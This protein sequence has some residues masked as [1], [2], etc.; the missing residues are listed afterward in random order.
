[1]VI[2]SSKKLFLAFLLL[3]LFSVASSAASFSVPASVYDEYEA[4]KIERLPPWETLKWIVHDYVAAEESAAELASRP[5]SQGRFRVF[6][7]DA[8]ETDWE[9]A[10]PYGGNQNV[11]EAAWPA[12]MRKGMLLNVPADAKEKFKTPMFWY[13]AEGSGRVPSYIDADGNY[14][15]GTHDP[16]SDEPGNIGYIT[17]NLENEMWFKEL[18]ENPLFQGENRRMQ[19]HL[20]TGI[21][22]YTGNTSNHALARTFNMIVAVFSKPSVFTP[23]EVRKLGKPVVLLHAQIHG[24]ENTPGE[25][26]LQIAKELSEGKHDNILDKIT[27][28]MVPRVNP[29]GAWLNTRGTQSL[30]PVGH[31][32]QSAGAFDMNRDNVGFEA[33]EIKLIRYLANEYNPIAGYDGHEQGGN[34]DSGEYALNASGGMTSNGYRR[35]YDAGISISTA[36][37]FNVHRD[38]RGLAKFIYEPIM[39][40]ELNKAK[41]GANWYRS[42]T[43]SG[44]PNGALSADVVSSDG[45]SGPI[46]GEI[47]WPGS[48]TDAI[49]TTSDAVIMNAISLGNQ[50]INFCSE[51]SRMTSN[52]IARLGAMRIVYGQYISAMTILKVSAEYLDTDVMPTISMARDLEIA[53]ALPLTF[54]G[55]PPTEHVAAEW[56]VLEYKDWRKEDVPEVVEAIAPGTRPIREVRAFYAELDPNAAVTR[57]VAYIIDKEHYLAAVRLYYTGIGAKIERLAQDTTIPVEAYTVLTTGATNLSPQN[58]GNTPQVPTG[59]RS[60]S[61]ADKTMTFPKDSFVVRMDSLGGIMSALLLEPMATNNFGNMWLSRSRGTSGNTANIPAWYRDNFLPV[62]IGKE[63]PAYRYVGSL[64]SLNTYPSRLNLPFVLTAVERVHSLTQAD[65]AK[66]KTQFGLEA[67]P[68]YISLF[69]LPVLSTDNYKNTP[70]VELNEAFL[71]PDGE[72]VKIKD[73]YILDGKDF[74]IKSLSILPAPPVVLIVAQKGLGD[75]EIYIAKNDGGFDTIVQETTKPPKPTLPPP[76]PESGCNAPMLI[77]AA[78]IPFM[79]IV[80][81]K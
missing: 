21:P 15:K 28:V 70:R 69:E 23:E 25:A 24:N 29:T 63:F 22:N 60:V 7:E 6:A 17:M 9:P 47:R 52:S 19:F 35:G 55:R 76:P 75:N 18:S 48:Q 59:I 44:V 61:K 11:S 66:I 38:V 12:S 53:N 43:L 72:V 30:A 57:P 42:A 37:N 33:L 45:V 54:W 14:V 77:L 49:L 74:D 27:V 16:K 46:S 20:V 36:N 41:I 31:A 39:I 26:M 8:E 58:S 34:Y 67:D 5:E 56:N 40:E 78:L 64:G 68:E 4:S 80:R 62:E 2:G 32:G 1:M 13:G 65:V 79:L 3:L 73:E 50:S 81:K 51:G 71:L 10:I